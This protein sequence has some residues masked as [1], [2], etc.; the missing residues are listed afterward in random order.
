MSGA[1]EL[2]FARIRWRVMS[3]SAAGK[4]VNITVISYV[5]ILVCVCDLMKRGFENGRQGRREKGA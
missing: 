5:H 2:H 3:N 1:I 4:G